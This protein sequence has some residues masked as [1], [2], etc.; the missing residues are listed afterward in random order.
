MGVAAAFV[1][2]PV[3]EG[4]EEFVGGDQPGQ[5]G[6]GEG[7]QDEDQDGECHTGEVVIG[8]CSQPI[9]R[10]DIPALVPSPVGSEPQVP[11]LGAARLE[12]PA[13]ARWS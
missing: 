1:G 12:L 6:D 4:F 7:E 9:M 13:P 5:S 2:Y 11:P 10:S 8:G 3:P